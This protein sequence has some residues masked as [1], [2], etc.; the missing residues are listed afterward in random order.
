LLKISYRIKSNLKQ[1]MPPRAAKTEIE[2]LILLLDVGVSMSTK[3]GNTTTTYLQSCVDIIQMIAQR[4]LFETSKDELSLILYGTVGTA[5]EL[6]NA[7]E[8][9]VYSHVSVA[10]PLSEVDWKL[11]EY[12]Q[13]NINATNLNGDTLDGLLVA[14]H[15]FQ[16]DIN[17]TKY[18]K[19]K[20]IM[21]LT[22][23]SSSADDDDKLVKLKKGL[24][25]NSIRLD[26]I[27]PFREEEEEEV[28]EEDKKKKKD[29]S[30]K[31]KKTSNGTASNDVNGNNDEDSDVKTMTK[32]QKANC[33]LL[34]Q[35]CEE[36]DG[37]MY[38]FDEGNSFLFHYKFKDFFEMKFLCLKFKLKFY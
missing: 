5:N 19:D 6:W 24:S 16:E 2:G 20:R 1:K 17:D 21:I 38:S 34:R 8:P 28:E 3:I 12:M 25:K 26:V 30:S 4:K 23:F 37:A 7:S 15:H 31:D 22:D 27:S 14:S 11:L 33:H 35:L 9:D 13:N 32:Q 29:N 18:F 10:R 36:T